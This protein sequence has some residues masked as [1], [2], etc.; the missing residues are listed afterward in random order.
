[1]KWYIDVLHDPVTRFYTHFH[2]CLTEKAHPLPKC[3][4]GHLGM[5]A[6]FLFCT[7][8]LK[9]NDSIVIRQKVNN[10]FT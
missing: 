2:T 9:C 10:Y 5:T 4:E 7:V 1:M 3:P 8:L 6:G